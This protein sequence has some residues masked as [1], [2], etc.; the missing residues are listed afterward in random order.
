MDQVFDVLQELGDCP[1]KWEELGILG[2]SKQFNTIHKGDIVFDT[3]ELAVNGLITHLSSCTAASPDSR[4][5]LT[6]NGFDQ[7]AKG[8]A[9]D[10]RFEPVF[11]LATE[12]WQTTLFP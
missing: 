10:A 3:V 5:S 8:Q 9:L 6:Y 11:A 7:N 12:E 4:L 2:R 1:V